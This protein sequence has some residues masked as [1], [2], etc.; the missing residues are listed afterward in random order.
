MK[1]IQKILAVDY[2]LSGPGIQPT[3]KIDATSKMENI[4]SQIIG[5][6]TIIA[7]VY[8]AI[9]I[10]MAGYAYL[11]TDG[12]EKKMESAR[13]RL[14]EGVLGLVIVVVAVGLGSLLATLAGIN[15][16]LNLEKLFTN[17]GL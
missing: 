10:I 6:L 7:V 3:D 8:F 15:D 5:V 1:L 12:D 11:T 13:K 14:T 17:M 9:Q 16:P 4:I 2:N